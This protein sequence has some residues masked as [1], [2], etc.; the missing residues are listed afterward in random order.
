MRNKHIYMSRKRL[1]C[2]I[3]DT[4][5]VIRDWAKWHF[6]TKTVKTGI[7]DN[8]SYIYAKVKIFT[9]NCSEYISLYVFQEKILPYLL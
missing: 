5:E 7:Y 8:L 2:S 6:R 3:Y 4:N 1:F 9:L